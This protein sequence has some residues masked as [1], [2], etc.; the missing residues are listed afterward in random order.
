MATTVYIVPAMTELAERCRIVA[1]DGRVSSARDNYEFEPDAWYEIGLMASDGR[2]ICIEPR[3]IDMKQ[4]EPLM[5]GVNY[6][7]G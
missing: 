4:D 2:L 5:A 1:R 6:H 7:F 3:F